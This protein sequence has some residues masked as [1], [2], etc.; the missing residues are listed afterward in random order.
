MDEG[1]DALIASA[2]DGD[3]AALNALFARVYGELKHLARKQ[4]AAAPGAT[5]NTTGLVHETYLKLAQPDGMSLQGRRHFFALSAKAMRQIVIDRARARLTDKRGGGHLQVVNID[6]AADLADPAEL[7][8][9]QLLRLDRALMALELDEPGLAELVD[10]RFFAGLAIAD[11]A[12]LRGV[13][14]RT[15]NRTWRRVR[16]QLHAALYP[17]A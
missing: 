2:C 10:L 8:P 7:G 12:A 13:S 16:A 4:L 9:E 17:D 5:L 14:E 3:P 11:I 15:L 1:I 6:D